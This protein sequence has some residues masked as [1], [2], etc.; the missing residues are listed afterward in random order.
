MVGNKMH[1]PFFPK[2]PKCKNVVDLW[3]ITQFL[4][5]QNNGRADRLHYFLH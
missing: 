1:K 2:R 4:K 5:E 3:D